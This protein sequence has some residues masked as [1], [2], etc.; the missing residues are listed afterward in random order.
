[1]ALHKFRIIIIIIIIIRWVGVREIKHR[2][3]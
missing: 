3:G 1:M 2:A